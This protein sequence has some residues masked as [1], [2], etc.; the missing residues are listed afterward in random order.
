M[1]EG[2]T[3]IVNVKNVSK[4]YGDLEALT[5]INF[6]VNSSEFFV[7]VG[8]SG[9]G[10]TTLL[11]IIAGLETPSSGSVLINGKPPDLRAQRIGFVF[12]EDS[13]FPW[14]TVEE[15]VRFG[16][17]I[18]RLTFEK[19]VKEMINLV[20]LRG[21]EHFHPH[22]ISGGM[23]KRA[24]IARALAVDP[25]LLLMD[26]PF[27]DLDAQTRWIMH[28]ELWSIHEKLRKTTVFVTHN[29]E[30]AVY[31]ADKVMVLTK[32]PGTVKKIIPIKLQRPRDKLSR[33]FINYREMIIQLLREEVPEI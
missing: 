2:S 5:N 27:G 22:Q 14:R 15:N 10:K 33:E 11:K 31:L 18:R 13:L 17:E 7:V 29:V 6:Q 16:L 19:R 12:Q 9:C 20:G 3:V 1:N 24:A 21:F 28:K 8:P 26:E 32:R 23:R 4:Y 25:F 30:E